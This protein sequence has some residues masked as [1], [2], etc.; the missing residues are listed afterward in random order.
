MQADSTCNLQAAESLLSAATAEVKQPRWRGALAAESA[1]V[2][3]I[4][5]QYQVLSGQTP[6][7]T[8][9]PL[10]RLEKEPGLTA[11]V[12]HANLRFASQA[13]CCRAGDL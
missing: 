7:L 13:C 3:D 12:V 9:V 6:T 2:Q 5:S 11:C 10:M 8:P 1:A 4:R